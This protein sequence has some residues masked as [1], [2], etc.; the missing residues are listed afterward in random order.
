MQTKVK[1]KQ[2]DEHTQL[3]K[4]IF[5]GMTVS[6][7]AQTMHCSKSTAMYQ[8]NLLYS[9]YNAKTR[10]EFFLNVFSEIIDNYKRMLEEKNE[11][12]TSLEKNNSEVKSLLKVLFENK[13]NPGAF[14]YW[15]QEIEKLF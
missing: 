13:N 1:S 11:K 14:N 7:I 3:A 6:Q 12:I 8:I 15:T 10:N 2:V 5:K 4:Y 9:K